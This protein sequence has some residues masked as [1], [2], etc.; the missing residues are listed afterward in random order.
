MS[1]LTAL[2]VLLLGVVAWLASFVLVALNRSGSPSSSEASDSLREALEAV[3]VEL[4]NLPLLRD[5]SVQSV[6]RRRRTCLL[7]ELPQLLDI[8]MLG[9][10]S[11]LS[12]DASL[13]LYCGRF[14]TQT[15]TLFR[16]ALTS[17]RNY[18]IGR[19]SCRERV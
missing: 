10:L 8:V 15:A 14:E 5:L 17:W 2:F 7:R 12:F 18:E 3:C 19:A 1:D 9:L 4:Q 11:G 6:R 13:E 16:E